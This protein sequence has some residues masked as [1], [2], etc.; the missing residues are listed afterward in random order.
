MFRKYCILAILTICG[1]IYAEEP[2]YSG[3]RPAS[4]IWI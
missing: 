4:P 3:K 1:T 2:L